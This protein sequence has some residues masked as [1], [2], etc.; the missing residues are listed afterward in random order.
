MEIT[1]TT[2]PDEMEAYLKITNKLPEE[3][4]DLEKLMETIRKAKIVHGIDYDALRQFCKEPVENVPILIAKGDPPKDGEPGKIVFEITT[5]SSRE[6]ITK[7]KI[8]FRE[9]PV[10]R[11]ILVKRGQKIATILPP[12][13]GV[14]GKNV[15]GETVPAKRGEEAKVV[16][17]KNV[18]LDEEGRYIVSTA[19]GLLKVDAEKNFI[20][21]SEYLEIDGDVDYTTG[22]IDFPGSVLVKGDVKPGFVVRAKGDIEIQGV[23]EAA[24]IIS[25]EGSVKLSGV[26][27]KDKGLVKAKKDIH[28]KYA[29][30]VT[31]EADNLYFETNLLGCIVRVTG[32]IIGTGK[33]SS[34]IGGEYV[35]ALK[36]EADEIGSEF[37]TNTYLEVGINPYLREEVKVLKA[38]IE[39]DK[40]SIQ[41]LLTIVKQYKDLKD[42]GTPI[43]PE[44]EEQFAKATRTLINLR[45]ELEKNMRKLEELQQKMG[46]MR[47][48][49]EIIARKVLYPG[50]EVVIHDARYYSEQQLPKVVLRYEDGKI[51][52]GGY[53]G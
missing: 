18:A 45:A 19:E 31:I 27:G 17:G 32:S 40:T 41:K 14:P 36:I 2:S 43:P 37:G 12:T 33:A 49:A 34:I 15:Y 13:E 39:I 23:V 50:V 24:T 25:L 29:E 46:K 47:F 6:Y 3:T 51:F 20:E 11:R 7:D 5:T 30:A 26:K 16:L 4:V 44:R 1:V 42:K 9:F 21:V 38:Q 35:A 28:V 10:Q 22:N 53:A 48:S 8:D 52:V